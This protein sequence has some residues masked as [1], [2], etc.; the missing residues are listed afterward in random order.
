MDEDPPQ[1]Q[2]MVSPDP[3]GS[4][5][6]PSGWVPFGSKATPLSSSA[7]SQPLTGRNWDQQAREGGGNALSVTGV[8]IDVFFVWPL[9][10]FLKNHCY[11]FIG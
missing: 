6:W 8:C 2:L 1:T 3:W 7:S 11:F 10:S 5:E 9:F 4:A